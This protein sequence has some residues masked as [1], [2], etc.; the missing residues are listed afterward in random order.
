MS[1]TLKLT[2]QFSFSAISSP[3]LKLGLKSSAIKYSELEKRVE[4]NRNFEPDPDF[5]GSAA[6]L[7][8]SFSNPMFENPE[9]FLRVSN[10]KTSEST[11]IYSPE[12]ISKSQPKKRYF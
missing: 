3:N 8:R 6:D 9:L 11:N 10:L 2:F 12:P 7:K 4:R 1:G 5:D